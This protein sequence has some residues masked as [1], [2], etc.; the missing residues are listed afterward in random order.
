LEPARFTGRIVQRIVVIERE[1]T[2][3]EIVFFD[4][5]TFTDRRRKLREVRALCIPA[6]SRG[7]GFDSGGTA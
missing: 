7:P 1:Q 4:F 2:A 6:P 5:D 3:R